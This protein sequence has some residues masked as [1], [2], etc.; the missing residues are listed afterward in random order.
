MRFSFLTL[1]VAF[2]TLGSSF[3]VDEVDGLS[4]KGLG[5]RAAYDLEAIWKILE[6]GVQTKGPVT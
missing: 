5:K 3:K 2:A 4:A 6:T 1:G